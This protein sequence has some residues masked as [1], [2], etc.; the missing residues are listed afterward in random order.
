VALKEIGEGFRVLYRDRV[1]IKLF[2]FF[3]TR[4]FGDALTA[5]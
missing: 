1:E 3:K 4:V 5:V 2:F